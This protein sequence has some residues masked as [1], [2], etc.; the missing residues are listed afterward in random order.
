VKILIDRNIERLSVTHV[1]EMVPR[2]VKFGPNIYSRPVAERVH[3]PPRE[4]EAFLRE[5]LPYLASFAQAARNGS[6]ECFTS[7]ELMMEASR[8][9]GP[10][11][12]L[13]GIDLFRGVSTRCVPTP[14]KRPIMFG[15]TSIGIT[16]EE[17]LESFQ[18][19]KSPRFLQIRRVVGDKHIADAFHLWTAEEAALDA[20]LTLDKR[21][22][23]V[24]KAQG[25]QIGSSVS[26]MTPKELC[27]RLGLE[28]TDIEKLAA[29]IN[30][31]R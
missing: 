5:Q 21:F 3:R 26:V 7:F 10:S 14:V 16:K 18:T 27:D 23:N 8:Q 9:K 17:Q 22:W 6:V 12:G 24:C 25:R 29:A 1:T 30:P 19:V 13:L 4:D 20:F 28:P 2:T 31:F 15:D 11:D